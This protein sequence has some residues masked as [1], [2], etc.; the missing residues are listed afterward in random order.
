MRL[1]GPDAQPAATRAQGPMDPID[2]PA[3]ILY[4]ATVERLTDAAVVQ[5]AAFATRAGDDELQATL[6]Q[7]LQGTTHLRKLEDPALQAAAADLLADYL[8][9]AARP[10]PGITEPG[11][12]VTRGMFDD[13]RSAIVGFVRKIDDLIGAA[14][15]NVAGS[16]QQWMRG[17][18]AEPIALTL[19][20]IVAYHQRRDEIQARLFTALDQQAPGWAAPNSLS[21]CWRT[22][23]AGWWRSMR[24]CSRRD[25][26][27]T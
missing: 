25:V 1:N 4:R 3:E 13:A 23:S 7:A 6:R 21:R 26:G 11:E 12:I 22:A 9:T 24:L 15:S 10:V 16:A 17:K 5:P 2:D 19:G 27:C 18:L 20:D 8:R 14:S